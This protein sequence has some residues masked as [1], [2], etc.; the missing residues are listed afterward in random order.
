MGSLGETVSRPKKFNTELTDYSTAHADKTGPYADNLQV[1][2][3]IVGAGFGKSPI[4]NRYIHQLT[5]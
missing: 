5:R 1:D 3:L 4:L 2:A